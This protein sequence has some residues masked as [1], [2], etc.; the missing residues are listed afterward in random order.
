MFFPTFFNISLNLAIRSSWSEPQ[1]AP[2]LVFADCIELLHLWLK[3]YN[4]SDFSIDRLE[5]SMCRVF[6]CVVE[7]GCLLWPVYSLGKTLLAF[8]LLHFVLQGQI[9]LLLQVYP[10]FSWQIDGKTLETV[11]DFF[12]VGSRI[13]AEGNCNHEIKSSLL[14]EWKAVA[15]LC[16]WSC[17]VVSDSLR[18]CGL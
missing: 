17:S 15:N 1:S 7:N 11:T 3:K 8:S 12:S 14:F 4:Q 9:Y 10:T 5:M 13:T 6:S 16:E 18:P 2:S